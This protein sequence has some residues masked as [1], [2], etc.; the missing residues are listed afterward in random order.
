MAFR[1]LSLIEPLLRAVRSQGYAAPTPI[2]EQVFPHIVGGRDVLGCAQT[3]TGK[4][5]AF[6]LPILQRLHE[7]SST[8]RGAAK[9]RRVI[10]CLVL[11]PTRELAAQIEESFK[12]YGRFTPLRATVIYGGVK[13]G[14][15]CAALRRGVDV[16]VATPGRL[17]DLMEQGEVSLDHV[18]VFV[19]D[20][21]DRMLDM[22]FIRDIRRIV[23]CL[24]GRRQTL[25]FSATMPG[26]IR[27]LADSIL[28]NPVTVKVAARSAA[29]D[30]V[31]QGVYYVDGR[32]KPK[33]LIRLLG[34]PD[35]AR[36]LVFCRT[37]RGADRVTKRL[38]AAGIDADAI[39]SDKT[40]AARQRALQRFKAG[41]TRVLV[42]SDIAARGIDVDRVSHVV[43]YDMPNDPETYVHRIGRTGRAG[44]AGSAITFCDDDGLPA[45][46]QI[47]KKL[48]RPVPVLSCTIATD[49]PHDNDTPR[50]KQQKPRAVHPMA[51]KNDSSKQRRRKRTT[52][53]TNG[54][55]GSGTKQTNKSRSRRTKRKQRARTST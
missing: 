34:D 9:P 52:K 46:R 15:Q 49:Q 27:K 20:E 2:Q 5:A 44:E 21:A 18:E 16:L 45:L 40:Q 26:E 54:A 55:T 17:M 42:A 10:R 50:V 31:E 48:K 6:A 43:N 11:T 47:E 1:K 12:V 30:T 36:T 28:H 38:N 13:Q 25:L 39:H 32:S 23:S 33:L 37:K 29:A 14:P 51:K 22:G 41:N 4:T 19:L 53:R 3:G 7:A 35:M 8:R 24:P